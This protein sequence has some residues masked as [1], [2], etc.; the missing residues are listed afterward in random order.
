MRSHDLYWTDINCTGTPYIYVGSGPEALVKTVNL[1]YWS[2]PVP[3]KLYALDPAMS[4]QSNV[5][6]K[7]REH[8]NGCNSLSTGFNLSGVMALD[9][10]PVVT[11]GLNFPW[12][13]SL[14]SP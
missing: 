13:A 2:R 1:L 14:E 10:A 3:G 4:N 7:S 6:F 5:F 12:T 11:V 8:W 9:P